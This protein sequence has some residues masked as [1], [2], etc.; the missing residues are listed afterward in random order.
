MHV[1]E[2]LLE[3]PLVKDRDALRCCEKGRWIVRRDVIEL[4][5]KAALVPPRC[6]R[7]MQERLMLGPRPQNSTRSRRV[8]PLVKIGAVPVSAKRRDVNRNRT[9]RVGSIHRNGYAVLMAQRSD[10][11]DR[12]HECRLRRHV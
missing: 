10:G 12:Q 1:R 8:R 6:N 5:M 4:L 11:G 9:W 2:H 3:S 7:V